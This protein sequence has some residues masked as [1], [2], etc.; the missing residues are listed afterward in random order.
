MAEQKPAPLD[1][2]D[3]ALAWQ[4][5]KPDDKEPW[6]LKWAGHLYR[7]AAFGATYAELRAAVEE[8]FPAAIDRIVIGEKDAAELYRLLETPGKSIPENPSGYEL[9]GWWLSVLLYSGH[10]LREKMTLFWHNHFVSS[11]AK[12]RQVSQMFNQNRM[13]RKH[14]LGKFPP[15]VLDVSKD[16]A[17][18]VYLDSNSNIKGKP[19]ENYAREVMELFSLGLGNYA[20]KDIQEAARA[21]T[22]WHTAGD[23][24][25]FIENYHDFET[26]TFLG[27]K[28]TWNGEDIVRIILEQPACARFLVRKLYHYLISETAEPPDALLEPLADRFRKSGNDISELVGTML[29]SRHFFSEHAY[30]KRVKCPVEFALGAI[31]AV[32][33]GEVNVQNTKSLPELGRK[34]DAMGQQLFAPPNVKG[35]P[36]GKSWLNTS[37]VLAR[38][39]FAQQ[40]ASGHLEANYS[41]RNF[42]DSEDGG[43][44]IRRPAAP[45]RSTAPPSDP[46]MDV[47]KLVAK[48]KVKEP[49]A[50]VE[51][52][53]DLFLQG[54]VSAKAKEKLVAFMEGGKPDDKDLDNR[55]RETAHAIMTMP[56][57]QLA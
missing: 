48:E 44:D 55:I 35:W 21:F 15:F 46:N 16:A 41:S 52:L 2:V 45:P 25:D 33:L 9:R 49:K 8:G 40:V 1:K 6:N 10:P 5:W 11:I 42:L 32:T 4:P 19:N 13:L 24:F 31:R 39:N 51:F 20:E 3:P 29:R 37:T 27:H 22:G 30:R 43:E 14:A 28:G 53:L 50:V 54:E 56:E 7:R 26:K 47:A 17:M 34:L 23:K 36:G 57:Y 38:H 18:L 12:V